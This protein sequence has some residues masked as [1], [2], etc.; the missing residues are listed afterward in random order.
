MM[1][2]RL[3]VTG[4]W[5]SRRQTSMPETEGSIQSST[6]R[7]GSFSSMRIRA[8]SPSAESSTR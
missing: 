8:S 2:G 4:R 3:R 1:I 5:R 7:S 6:T